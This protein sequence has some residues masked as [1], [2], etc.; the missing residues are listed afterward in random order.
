MTSDCL[1]WL[2]RGAAAR[3]KSESKNKIKNKIKGSGQECPLHTG[4]VGTPCRADDGVQGVGIL[5]LR[6]TFTSW[7][8]CFAQDDRALVVTGLFGFRRFIFWLES[9]WYVAFG[10]IFVDAGVDCDWGIWDWGVE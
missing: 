2:S 8:S 6:M 10:V 5:R 7:A 9:F 1:G 4:V 3:A